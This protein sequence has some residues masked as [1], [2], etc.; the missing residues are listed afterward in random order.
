MDPIGIIIIAIVVAVAVYIFY[1]NWFTKKNG[2]ETEAVVSRIEEYETTD[3]DGT[4][5][6]YNYYV[7]YHDEDGHP[8]EARISNMGFS[9]G[10]IVGD[11]IR[12]KYLPE[13]PGMAVWIRK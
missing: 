6:S 12:I 8:H 11:Q 2:T 4:S 13:K 10:L 1:R 9:R 7:R 3:S 5:T